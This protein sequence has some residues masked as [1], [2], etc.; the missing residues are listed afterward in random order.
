M[1]KNILLCNDDE[2][3]I[4]KLGLLNYNNFL[5][6]EKLKGNKNVNG[7]REKVRKILEKLE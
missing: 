7:R 6:N 5:L 2:I 4:I 1:K 3:W